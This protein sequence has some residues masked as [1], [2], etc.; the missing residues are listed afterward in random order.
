[1]AACFGEVSWVSILLKGS[2][3]V[4]S[5]G[6]TNHFMLIVLNCF[7]FGC[8]NAALHLSAWGKLESPGPQLPPPDPHLSKVITEGDRERE[9]LIEFDNEDDPSKR[10]CSTCS[11]SLQ[12]SINSQKAPCLSQEHCVGIDP[13]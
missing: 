1:M 9:A 2:H 12:H 3:S 6:L 8:D 10:L 13:I 7:C 11:K 4:V 5:S